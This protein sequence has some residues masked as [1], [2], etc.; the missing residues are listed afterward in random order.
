MTTKESLIG[1]ALSFG[2]P[3][4]MIFILWLNNYLLERE[5]KLILAGKKIPWGFRKK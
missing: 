3:G 2:I 5:T 4:F 1:I